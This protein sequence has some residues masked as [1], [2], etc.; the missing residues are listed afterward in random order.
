M[1]KLINDRNPIPNGIENGARYELT[2]IDCTML[3]QTDFLLVAL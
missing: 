1:P 3:A 2:P